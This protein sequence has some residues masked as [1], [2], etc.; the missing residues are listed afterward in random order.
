MIRQLLTLIFMILGLSVSAQIINFPFIPI[1]DP[2]VPPIK[3]GIID[4]PK[5]HLEDNILY[6]QFGDEDENVWMQVV[7]LR[8]GVILYE[9]TSSNRI[10]FFPN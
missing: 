5:G 1:P 9:N 8:E 3:K 7:L 6:I 10:F 4:I 2:D